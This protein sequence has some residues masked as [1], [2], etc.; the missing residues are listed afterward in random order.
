MTQPQVHNKTA[1]SRVVE[2]LAERILGG[3]LSPGDRLPAEAALASEFE[4][5]RPI[6]REALGQLRERGYLQTI[7]GSGTYVR[8]PDAR[9]IA[10]AFQRHLRFAEGGPFTVAQLYETRAAIEITAA[11][12]AAHHA[13]PEQ[14]AALAEIVQRMSDCAGDRAAYAAADMAFHVELARASGNPLLALVLEPLVETI[15]TGMLESHHVRGA[16][17]DGI[18]MHARI[19]AFVQAGDAQGA[20]EAM[21]VHLRQSQEVFPEHALP[22]SPGGTPLPEA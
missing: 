9:T 16:T 8:R 22:M 6:V 5:S 10:Q 18:S 2:A 12:R 19:L 21:E 11:R 13:E 17:E 7:N 1:V 20:A 15:V 14:C 4:V 3:A